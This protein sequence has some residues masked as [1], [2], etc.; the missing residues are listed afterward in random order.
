MY[1]LSVRYRAPEKA[2]NAI[3]RVD[4][5]SQTL[6][7]SSTSDYQSS[8]VG[9]YTLTAGVH[10]IGLSSGV[11]EGYICFDQVCAKPTTSEEGCNPPAAP[12]ISVN[13][14]TQV[15]N[16]SSV[17]LTASGCSGTITWST[18]ATG[19][20]L[21]VKTA[22]DYT[23]SCLVGS[24]SSAL[25]NT[26]TVTSC[27]L[28]RCTF[29][30]TASA[31]NVNLTC[32]A[33]VNLTAGCSGADCDGV[34]YSW[35]GQGVA[36]YGQ[37]ASVNAPNYNGSF[38][39][40]V[41]ASKLGCVAKKDSVILS[42]T[43]CAQPSSGVYSYRGDNF[44]YNPLGESSTSDVFPV[45]END[46]IKVKL[47]LRNQTF[48]SQEP[49]MGGAVYQLF[50]KQHNATHTLIFN[51][52]RYNG[53]DHSVVD[54]SGPPNRIGLGGGLSECLYA[55]PKPL[56]TNEFDGAAG[57]S[58]PVNGVNPGG[59][60]GGLGFNPNEVGDDF[61]NSGQ[62]LKFGRTTS[63]FYTKTRPP[64]Y[65][66]NRFFAGDQIIFEK[67]GSLDDRALDLHYQSTFKRTSYTGRSVTKSQ[68]NPCLYVN[69]LRIVKFYD[70]NNP[71]TNDGV[72]TISQAVGPNNQ[73]GAGLNGIRPNGL[74]LSEPWIWIGGTDGYGI[75]LL[76][77][78]NIKAGYGFFG[79]GGFIPDN[80][81]PG[82]SYG[83]I[84]AAAQEILDNNIIWRHNSKVIVGTVDEVRAYVYAQS[85]RPDRTPKIKF[86]R[87]GREGWSLNSGDGDERYIWDDA[88][89]GNARQGWKL[90]FDN[91]ANAVI[92]SP[93][94][95]WEANQF[96]KFY[97]RYK[98]S[99]NQTQW[100]LRFQR[101]RQKNN[102]TVDLSGNNRFAAEDAIRYANGTS[103]VSEQTI[104]F[105]VIPDNQWHVAVIDLSGN[106][107]WQGVINHISIKPHPFIGRSYD[108][109]ENA[110]VDWINSENRDP[111][112]D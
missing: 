43:G 59:Y 85:Y 95:C 25:S 94:V 75:G 105:S 104:F 40:I 86:N 49:G 17:N 20:N 103:D 82:G 81:G 62:L 101:N 14:S 87:P 37:T 45:F 65:G 10:T 1:T 5:K 96:K 2:V 19:S 90:Y 8:G 30:P 71:Y 15:C 52:N 83:Y 98:Y 46:K 24:C 36:Q 27:D 34:N 60:D 76:I 79:D 42:V 11:D 74:Y 63:G 80:P 55:L 77:K 93:G 61:M 111:F 38:T 33:S 92:H 39:Y 73:N 26:I 53:D 78:D 9:S 28:P 99:G 29:T 97:I 72:T 32:G 13:G 100:S 84:G 107:A 48:N 12:V 7:L 69:G 58:Y 108:S 31:S 89:D 18:G 91:S 41:T 54:R 16:E 35:N 88:F 47:A 64:I 57:S 66:Q 67:W 102:G 56:Y 22:G 109:G 3:V 50:N 21:S 44:D 23:A 112:P 51:P 4:G 106:N 6:R 70:G 68:E 110:I